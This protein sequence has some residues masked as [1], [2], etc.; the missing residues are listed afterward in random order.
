MNKNS[1]KNKRTIR[2]RSISG[3]RSEESLL[4]FDSDEDHPIIFTRRRINI[5]DSDDEFSGKSSSDKGA[6]RFR[7]CSKCNVYV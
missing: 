1:S 2:I 6:K 4:D 5:V 7:K 3:N